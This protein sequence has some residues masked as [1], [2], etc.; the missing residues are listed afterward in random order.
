MDVEMNYLQTYWWALT[1]RGIAALVFGI[2]A[3]FW[4]GITLVVLLYLFSAWILVDG[5]IRVVAGVSRLGHHQMGVLSMLVGLFGF[6]VGVYLLRHPGVTFTTLILLV[7][8]FLIFNGIVEIVVA[9]TSPDTATGKTLAIIGGV[10][11]L[12]AGIL[13]LFQ[14]A[15]AGV[16]FVWILGLY[17]LVTGPMLIALSLDIHRQTQ[18][19]IAK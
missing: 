7:G 9:L 5:V 14:P 18:V 12:L 1:L 13:M 4:P 6:G 17:G 15:T 2:A 3:V 19:V 11:A 16:A 8:F 10:A